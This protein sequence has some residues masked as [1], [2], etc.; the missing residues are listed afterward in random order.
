MTVLSELLSAN[1][2]Y[3]ATFTKGNLPMPPG[4]QVTIVTCMDA[5]LD[6]AKFLGLKEGDAH[7]IRNAG[8]RVSNDVLR[9]L[10]ISQQLLGTREVVVIHHTDCGMM[11]FNNDELVARIK[12]DLGVDASGRDFYPFSDLEASVKEDVAKLRDNK[13]I[14]KSIPIVGAIY[15]VKNGRVREVVQA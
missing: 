9:S 5:R 10:A 11:T 2:D 15:D 7:V 1:T 3:S 12:D 6:P 8:G 4:R 13:L 14:P